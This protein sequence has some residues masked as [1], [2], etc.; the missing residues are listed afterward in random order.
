LKDQSPSALE[1]L[2][3]AA[4]ENGHYGIVIKE[5]EPTIEDSFIHL[6]KQGV[7]PNIEELISE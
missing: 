5:I 1:K 4:F 2:R 7:G 6:M 3:Q